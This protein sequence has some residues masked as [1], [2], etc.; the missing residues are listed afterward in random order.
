M[1]QTKTV[2]M[3][4]SREGM[5]LQVPV[6]TR[7][8]EGQDVPALPDAAAR[9]WKALAAFGAPLDN[10]TPEDFTQPG[11]VYQLGVAPN[12][13]DILMSIK[14][15]DYETAWAKKVESAYDGVPIFILGKND[16]IAAKKASARPQDLL[17]VDLLLDSA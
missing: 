2:R 17:D 12:R 4:Y 5:A 8:L 3:L 7:V 9:V 13:I 1:A 10:V 15:V 11:L 16:L 14:G 6:S